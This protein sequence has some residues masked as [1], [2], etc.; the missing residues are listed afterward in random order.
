[1]AHALGID[2]G[3][4]KILAGVVDT[5]TGEVL[6]TARK[7][8]RSEHGPDDVMARLMV[9][10]REALDKAG[11]DKSDLI[12]IGVGAAGLVDDAHGTLLRAPNLPEGMVG[13]PL[14]HTIQDEFGI[15]TLLL[16][17]VTAAAAGEAAFGAGAGHPD[18]VCV[19][20]GTGIGGSIYR[21]GCPYHGSTNT[22][23][24]LG[25]MVIQYDGR[26][27]GC[28]G[29]GH[30]EAYASRTAV[31]RTILASMKQGR[32]SSLAEL[33]PNPNPEDPAH[34]G[35]RSKALR[36]A[37][38]A[39]DELTRDMI[40]A[41]ARYMGAG[42]ASIINFYNPPRIIL[43]GGMVQEVDLFFIDAAR[44]AVQG[45]LAVPRDGVEIVRAA[46]GDNSGIV[47]AAEQAARHILQ[48]DKRA[49][50]LVTAG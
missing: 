39:G 45:A 49:S 27:C 12:A 20:A 30:L 19:F 5:D 16:N 1:M 48:Q 10:A 43:G 44:H 21:D 8:T 47:G 42:L 33:E 37:I 24:E 11:T 32:V 15:P 9:A 7:R 23:G 28:G 4:T 34:S 6:A 26:L 40:E 14:A 41:G 29:R 38:D 3:G 22:A 36:R 2:L 50:T 25:H 17:D 18:F 35:I 13:T 31:V 46:L